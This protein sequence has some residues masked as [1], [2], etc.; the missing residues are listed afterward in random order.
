MYTAN[1]SNG[2]TELSFDIYV[3]ATAGS[4]SVLAGILIAP[5]SFNLDKFI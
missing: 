1:I 5:V 2:D 3:S 4:T